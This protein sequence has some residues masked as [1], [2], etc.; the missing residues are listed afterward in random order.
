[1]K[2]LFKCKT[3]FS[4]CR[5][6][7]CFTYCSESLFPFLKNALVLRAHCYFALSFPASV[8]PDRWSKSKLAHLFC[9]ILETLQTKSWLQIT[10]NYIPGHNVMT[11]NANECLTWIFLIFTAKFLYILQI[12]YIAH[13]W[14]NKFPRHIKM[15]NIKNR[16]NIKIINPK[17]MFIELKA[18][19]IESI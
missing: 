18:F 14:W 17:D 11:F 9:S 13:V 19:C 10:P 15:Y 4:D 7:N 5:E 2:S 8:F 16:D 6:L 12:A 1:M 3:V